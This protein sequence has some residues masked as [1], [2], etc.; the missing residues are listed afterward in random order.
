MLRKPTDPIPHGTNKFD[1]DSLSVE[2]KERYNNFGD[3]WMNKLQN[4]GPPPVAGPAVPGLAVQG[5]EQEANIVEI[6]G[7]ESLI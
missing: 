2:E 6:G 1:N 3:A 7:E 5:N 4:E